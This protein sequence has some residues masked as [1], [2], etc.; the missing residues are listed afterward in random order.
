M[1]KIVIN[2][3]LSPCFMLFI[4]LILTL[5]IL[6]LCF[7]QTLIDDK[8]YDES[9]EIHHI[10][11]WPYTPDHHYRILFIGG[12]G[13]GKTNVFMNRSHKKQQSLKIWV[14]KLRFLLISMAHRVH[15]KTR[16]QGK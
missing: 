13:S 6:L 9:V 7:K 12:S 4:I 5:K 8:S 11:N 10:S 14:V 3:L 15:N 2:Y 1:Y 16:K